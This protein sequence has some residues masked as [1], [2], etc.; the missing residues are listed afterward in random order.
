[1]ADKKALSNASVM[2]FC[3]VLAEA[4]NLA[5]FVVISRLQ[6]PEGVGVYAYG[7]AL[8]GFVYAAAN[9]GVEQYGVREYHRASPAE[10]RSMLSELLGLQLAVAA[11]AAAALAAYLAATGASAST[12]AVVY[13]LSLY[14]FC[15]AVAN[16]LFVPVYAEQQMWRASLFALLSRGVAFA[17]ASL[18][19]LAGAPDLAV[20]MLAF[21]AMAL[22]YAFNAW[23]SAR[24]RVGAV[25][26]HV[27]VAALRRAALALRSFAAVDVLGQLLSRA[28]VIVLT[29]ALGAH[30][31]GVFATGLKFVEVAFLPLWFVGVAVYPR[32]CQAHQQASPAFARLA[33]PLLLVALGMTLL[34][35][36]FIY[37]LLPPLL[38][39][40]LGDGYAGA[41]PAIQA[42][43]LLALVWGAEIALGRILFAMDQQR[44]RALIV[45]AGAATCTA[46]NIALAPQAGVY[47]AIVAA[48]ISY[49]VV[50]AWY[51]Y[52]CLGAL[53]RISPRTA[54]SNC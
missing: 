42:M 47:G 39:P 14:Q 48:A 28:G 2:L 24:Q 8:A 27:S 12:F 25:R 30:A 1:M 4:L 9:L 43:S 46:L 33:A 52:Y 7:F 31:A 44:R 17:L 45:A 6:G 19:L 18:V 41:E 32:L 5:L 15:N 34:V 53:R 40:M 16:T 10:R 22:L 49:L 23:R 37:A 13:A 3:R 50:D 29:L 51:A 21:P 20:A 11:V 38:V 54:S 36:L 35:T 26:P